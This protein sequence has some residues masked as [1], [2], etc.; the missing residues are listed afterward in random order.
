MNYNTNNIEYSWS[1]PEAR[2][3]SRGPDSL[4]SH[5]V[6]TNLT[7]TW[8]FVLTNIN[9][10]PSDNRLS[11]TLYMLRRQICLFICDFVYFVLN[12][13]VFGW[14]FLSGHALKRQPCWTMF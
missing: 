14:F 12:L 10:Y 2:L 11:T 5:P 8:P 4:I 9:I 7:N 6:N 13:A 1:R 3:L